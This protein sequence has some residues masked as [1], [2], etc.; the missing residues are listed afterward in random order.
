[1]KIKYINLIV[2]SALALSFSGCFEDD[3]TDDVVVIPSVSIDINVDCNSTTDISTYITTI[4][5]DTIIQDE[6]NTSVSIFFDV[7][8]TK[9]ICLE[10]GKAH[11]LR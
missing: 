7:N 8:A 9:K 4:A 3:T 10:S 2:A 11:I 6:A 1:M 5:G